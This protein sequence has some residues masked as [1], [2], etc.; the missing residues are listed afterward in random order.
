VIQYHVFMLLRNTIRLDYTGNQLY[1]S[2][3]ENQYRVCT[4]FTQFKDCQVVLF[5]KANQRFKFIQ[6]NV[7]HEARSA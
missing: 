5:S 4:T 6:S 1:I 3:L 7:L 2:I